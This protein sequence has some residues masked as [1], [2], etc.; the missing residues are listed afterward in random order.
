MVKVL[1]T[2]K[3]LESLGDRSRLDADLKIN[4]KDATNDWRKGWIHSSKSKPNH[5]F[6]PWTGELLLLL[7]LRM[8]LFVEKVIDA[9]SKLEWTHWL[10]EIWFQLAERKQQNRRLFI[11]L[12][13]TIEKFVES[14]ACQDTQKKVMTNS[15]FENVSNGG[16]N[17]LRPVYSSPVNVH[18][19][20]LTH[21]ILK[22]TTLLRKSRLGGG[23]AVVFAAKDNWVTPTVH[24]QWS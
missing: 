15:L 12:D 8:V 16:T 21:C 5:K 7:P 22:W 1:V 6:F 3:I 14:N 2:V 24:L 4:R 10:K 17:D 13:E 18:E 23:A 20:S 19:I 11:Q 9:F